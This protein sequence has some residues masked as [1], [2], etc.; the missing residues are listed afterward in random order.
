[1]GECPMMAR[2]QSGLGQVPV[3]KGTVSELGCQFIDRDIPG[4]SGR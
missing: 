3:E 1:M 4:N 2:V